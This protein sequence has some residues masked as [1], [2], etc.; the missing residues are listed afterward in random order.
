MAAAM[1]VARRLLSMRTR[2]EFHLLTHGDFNTPRWMQTFDEVTVVLDR[3]FV[4][5]LVRDGLP[6][7]RI[8][9]VT[10]RS[11]SDVTIAEYA[12]AFRLELSD[13][14]HTTRSLPTR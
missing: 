5:D 2:R 1:F 3:Q 11:A 10:Q 13:Q 8:A 7:D 12:S 4:S 6:P 14:C 9:F